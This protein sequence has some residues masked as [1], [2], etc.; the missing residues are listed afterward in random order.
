MHRRQDDRRHLLAEL[1][2]N[3]FI[4]GKGQQCSG[5]HWHDIRQ[6]E[7]YILLDVEL[8][9]GEMLCSSSGLVVKSWALDQE[10]SGWNPTG[11]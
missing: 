11:S 10:V 9:G 3:K 4:A 2:T 8:L 7:A 1:I 6:E 5:S